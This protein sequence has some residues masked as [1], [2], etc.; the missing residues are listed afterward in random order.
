M[1]KP[2]KSSPVALTIAGSDSSGG[3]GIQADLKA[4]DICG[5]FGTCVITC[6]TAQNTKGVQMIEPPSQKIIAAQ[7]ECVLSDLKPTAIKTGMLYSAEIIEIVTNGLKDYQKSTINTREKQRFKLVVDP[8]MQATTGMEL[9]SG[10]ENLNKFIDALKSSLFPLATVITPNI[11]EAENI[12]GWKIKTQND[13]RRACEELHTLGS[14]YVLLKG[15]HLLREN[16]SNGISAEAVD[17]LYN[18]NFQSYT[19]SRHLK[20]V[21]GTGCTF[22][23]LITGSLARGF[24]VP[25]AVKNAKEL[26]TRCIEN[27]LTVGEGVEVVN[28][29]KIA[30]NDSEHTNIKSQIT[31]AAEELT[32]ILDP[33]V[34]PEVG[35]NIGYALDDANT[36]QDVCALTGRL[37]RVGQEVKYLGEAEFGA[38]KHIARIILTVMKNDEKVRAAMNIRYRPEI[39]EKCE[40]LNY[41]I[42]TFDRGNEPKESSTM[43]WGTENAIKDLGF[44][45]D[46]IFDTGGIGKEP[47][48]RILGTDPEDV[49]KKIKS[50]VTNIEI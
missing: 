1:I 10:A 44:V 49:I 43:E 8:V 12:L 34:M 37:V 9:T 40:K 36:P 22:A 35:I 39:V 3:A 41:T 46:I 20:D 15:G 47:M 18:G 32:R 45:P 14:K 25:S 26:I 33:Y 2:K 13:M 38:S 50:I 48:I 30:D 21:H 23:A 11:P 16:E 27:S 17:I 31:H 29:S 24:D 4:F 5:V 7:L 6:I 19:K 28:I 42:G